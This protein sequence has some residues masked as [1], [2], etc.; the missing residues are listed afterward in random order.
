LPEK[1]GEPFFGV[2]EVF[3]KIGQ[4]GGKNTLTVMLLNYA[5]YLWCC[6]DD[7]H[8]YFGLNR[9]ENFDILVYSQVSERQARNV[10][11]NNLGLAMQN[12]IDPIANENW[13]AKHIGMRLQE[14]G[15]K[16]IKEKEMTI[17]H[18][19]KSRGHIRIFC[20]DT[21]AKSVEGYTIWIRITD[22]PS[23][24][25]TPAKYAVAKHQYQTANGNQETR[26]VEGFRLGIMFAYPEQETNDL[27]VELYNVYSKRNKENDIEINNGVLTA[28]YYSYIF[29]SKLT[30]EDYIK[31]LN[32]PGAD[33]IDI[34][35]RWKAIVPPNKYGFFM[36][37]INKI[38]ECANPN[39][40]NPVKYRTTI[41]ERAT[42]VNGKEEIVRFTAIELLSIIRDN[43]RRYWGMDTSETGDSFIIVSG[44]PDVLNHEI[45]NLSIE[46]YNKE[47]NLVTE[48]IAF[49]CKPIIDIIIKYEP[50][51]EYPVDYTNV[52]N[53]LVRLLGDEFK[54]S[55]GIRSDKYQSESLRQKMLDI[56]IRG[57]EAMFF[58]NPVQVRMGKIVRHLIWNN[59]IE[60]PDD[61]D[62]IREMQKLLLINNN[63]I[64]HP[65]GES[66]DIYDAL[67][68]C[69]CQIIESGINMQALDIE[70]IQV[71]GKDENKEEKQKLEYY[72]I[73]LKRFQ[74]KY[75]RM[76]EDAR[77]F[78][79]FMH[80]IGY[81]FDEYDVE[82]CEIELSY[83]NDQIRQSIP[84][85]EDY[86]KDRDLDLGF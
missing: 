59:A 41:T 14:Y 49:N 37:Y 26:F 13:Y 85:I 20:L 61:P 39:I 2:K 63:K 74:E 16:D 51:K 69:V 84:N 32:K 31:A 10:F 22:E 72:K 70:G 76:Y 21:T 67:V 30:E 36:P 56:G 46:H 9:Q 24:A 75:N 86:H 82:L 29:N 40:V 64:D 73:G 66:K 45:S 35:R 47:G 71:E 15:H 1:Y 53:I 28:W 62:L 7:P 3:M 83:N 57:A 23:R 17:F 52:E 78:C 12:T 6:M 34:D 5:I 33:R 60:Y 18:R 81:K 42:R 58:S 4:G 77:E 8:R 11:F 65:E 79:R 25:N 50:S 27:L 38:N 54:E 68:N 43:R 19:D 80:E 44:Y 55:K 48:E